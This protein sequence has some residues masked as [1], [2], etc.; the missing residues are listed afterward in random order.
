[1]RS[2]RRRHGKRDP[3]AAQA[4]PGSSAES[5]APG[6]VASA[7][8]HTR[9]GAGAS[10]PR[11]GGRWAARP[12]KQSSRTRRNHPCALPLPD[13]GSPANVVGG[14]CSR[15]S[16]KAGLAARDPR[17]PVFATSETRLRI[18]RLTGPPAARLGPRDP[19]VRGQESTSGLRGR[20][21]DAIDAMIALASAP[22]VSPRRRRGHQPENRG[23]LGSIPS[24]AI[25]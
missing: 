17:D 19:W 20:S 6:A 15:A 25:A 5:R 9:F 3:G 11:G 16:T 21:P 12:A 8:G 2:P 18:R 13:K 23:V 7:P 4:P 10:P 24:L 22:T 1:M 14:K